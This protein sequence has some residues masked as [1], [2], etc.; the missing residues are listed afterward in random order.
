MSIKKTQGYEN[1]QRKRKSFWNLKIIAERKRKNKAKFIK[2]VF[3]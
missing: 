1:G 2:E 3:K